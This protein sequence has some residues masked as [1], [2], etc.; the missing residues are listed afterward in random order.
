MHKPRSLSPFPCPPRLLPPVQDR[1]TTGARIRQPFRMRNRCGEALALTVH[2]GTSS[3]EEVR[4]T[5]QDGAE[6]TV[7]FGSLLAEPAA[8][9]TRAGEAARS[10]EL[11][12][13]TTPARS[14]SRATTGSPSV[15]S[16]VV[17][18]VYGGGR[19]PLSPA[20]ARAPAAPALVGDV[21]KLAD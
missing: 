17:A 5:L 11:S 9:T 15:M 2:R 12:Q 8:S 16:G 13:P 3:R 10:G 6:D 7:D 20:P 1:V 4:F 21:L 14:R 19:A 18:G